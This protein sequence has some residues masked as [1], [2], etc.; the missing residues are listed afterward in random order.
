MKSVLSIV[1]HCFSILLLCFSIT[2]YAA[3]QAQQIFKQQANSLYQIRLIDKISGNKSSIGSGFQISSDGVIATNYHVIA[4]YAN[5]PD[6]YQ[7]EYLDQQANKGALKLHSVDVIN[8]L[9][10]LKRTVDQSMH[11]FTM[12]AS[13]PISG[14]DIFSL[15][16]PHDLGMIVVPGTYNGLKK[17]AFNE[18]IHFTG[19]INSG[20]SGGPVVNK[21]G[22][23]VGV[24]VATSGNQIGFLIPHTKLA[25]LYQTYQDIPGTPIR[26]QISQQLTHY[27]DKL[28]ST[29]LASQWQLK[30]LGK[31]IIPTIPLP[32]IRCWGVSNSD[33][34]DALMS[35]AA[36]SCAMNERK[37]LSHHFATGII[38]MEFRYLQAKA[39]TDIKFYHLYEQQLQHAGAN[40]P[41]LKENV[42]DFEC[43]HDIVIPTAQ[44]IKNKTIFCV[45]AYRQYPE[46]FDVLYLSASIDK[47]DQALVSYFSLSGVKQANTLAFTRRFMESVTWGQ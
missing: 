43:Q 22:Q 26:Q 37:Y 10:L 39:L 1:L 15:G 5:S 47:H 24:N 11:F 35:S 28:I 3:K 9:A 19:A 38:K 8:D 2:S 20:M 46:L 13:A 4:G 34:P 25:A 7:I 36:A 17:K 33:K 40:N 16:N 45:R 23:V 44:E 14:E 12:A 30:Q 27:Q 32:Y 6:K 29:L 42:S 21:A 41:T 18:R 31:G